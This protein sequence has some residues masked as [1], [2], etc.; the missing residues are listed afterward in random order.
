VVPASTQHVCSPGGRHLHFRWSA[1]S[2]LSVDVRG[3]ALLCA[4]VAVGVAA[5]AR[6]KMAPSINIPA[7]PPARIDWNLARE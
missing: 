5:A 6:K 7:G 4:R 2:G 3:S 1:N